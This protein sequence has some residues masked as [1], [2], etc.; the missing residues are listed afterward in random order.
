MHAEGGVFTPGN[1]VDQLKWLPVEAATAALTHDRDRDLLRRFAEG[2]IVTRTVLLV[3][4]ATAGARQKWKGDDRARP[5]DAHGVRQ[6]EE[7]VWLLT[8]WDVRGIVTADVLRCVQTMNSLAAA[9]GL[10]IEECSALSED[11]YPERAEE[12]VELVRGLGNRHFASVVCTQGAVIP[13]LL[14][15]LARADDVLLPQDLPYKKGS[16]VALTFY[17]RRLISCEYFP[18]PV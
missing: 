14:G 5:I 10:A 4:H 12:A 9:I 17:R 13:D 16:V 15:R 7:L 1:E 18:P 2:P 3:R 6:A 11:A 8:R